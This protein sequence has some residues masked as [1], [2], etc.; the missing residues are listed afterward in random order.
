M[1]R[2]YFIDTS[3]FCNV[4]PVPGR[5]QQRTEVL[6]QLDRRSK[7]ATLILPVTTVIETG[8][9]IA[10]LPS[11]HQ[12]RA[13]ADLFVKVLELICSGQAPWTLHQFTWDVDVIR[14]IIAGAGTQRTLI[15]NAEAKV[16]AGDLTILAEM[17]SYAERTGI[18]QVEVWA[19]DKT[20]AA[21]G[22]A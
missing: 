4:L 10:Q 8:N 2:V 11:G 13:T 18:G 9:F 6:E 5:D 14:D 17:R 1:P 20:L 16:G 15:D 21:F 3:V 12:R 7:A 19:L 22:T